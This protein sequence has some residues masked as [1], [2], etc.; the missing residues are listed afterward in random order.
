MFLDI[1]IYTLRKKYVVKFNTD[2]NI[3]YNVNYSF[4]LNIKV[5]DLEG[6]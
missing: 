4:K 6:W 2:A 5:N 1:A 3:K